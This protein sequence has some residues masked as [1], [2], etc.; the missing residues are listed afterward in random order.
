VA[1]GE[2]AGR[3]TKWHTQ[4]RN[5]GREMVRGG[6]RPAPGSGGRVGVVRGAAGEGGPPPKCN[7]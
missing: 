5:P 4:V 1:A 2:V 7:R 3:V 6:T